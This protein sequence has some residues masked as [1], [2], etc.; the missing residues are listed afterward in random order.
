V[1]FKFKT[2]FFKISAIISLGM[3]LLITGIAWS[4]NKKRK[5]SLS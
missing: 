1:I 5:H 4:E 2:P 3:I